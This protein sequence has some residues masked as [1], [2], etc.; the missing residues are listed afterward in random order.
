MTILLCILFAAFVVLQCL[1][2]HST[3]AALQRP[4]VFEANPVVRWFMDKLGILSALIALKVLSI[5]AI[6]AACFVFFRM[7]DAEWIMVLA[8]LVLDVLYAVVVV[9]NYSR[10]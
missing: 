9:K 3:N 6:G 8:L 10:R 1:D 7:G 2:V 5:S 4:D